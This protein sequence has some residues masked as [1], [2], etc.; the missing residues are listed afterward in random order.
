MGLPSLSKSSF[1]WS[2]A[3]DAFEDWDSPCA[4]SMVWC[5][6]NV[7]VGGKALLKE[8]FYFFLNFLNSFLFRSIEPFFIKSHQ[9]RSDPFA[10][11]SRG[12]FNRGVIHKWEIIRPHN[13]P[14]CGYQEQLRL[15]SHTG[16][17]NIKALRHWHK[18]VQFGEPVLGI[19]ELGVGAPE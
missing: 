15:E 16:Y 2:V 8:I 18:A 6:V 17:I 19:T 9:A 10:M 4:D 1:T 12:L 13:W 3:K 11:T 7:W 14:R 5:C